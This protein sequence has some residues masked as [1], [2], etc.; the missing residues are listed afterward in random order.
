MKQ[1]RTILGMFVLAMPTVASAEF[2]E[3]KQVIFGMD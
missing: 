1:L 2:K 3:M